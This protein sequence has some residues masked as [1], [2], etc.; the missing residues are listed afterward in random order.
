MTLW[1]LAISQRNLIQ[2]AS[3]APDSQRSHLSV[4]R[5][6]R[7]M[8]LNV[9]SG[10]A[11]A[12][13]TYHFAPSLLAIALPVAMLWCLAPLLMSGLSRQPVRKT[14]ALNPDQKQLRRQRPGASG[15]KQFVHSDG[16]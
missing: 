12:M 9:V 5:F 2:W 10:V 7:A 8:W 3:H 1:R 15:I 14:I 11:L 16:D 13:M 6:Y 4:L